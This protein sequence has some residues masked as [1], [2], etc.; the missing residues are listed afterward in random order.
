MEISKRQKKIGKYLCNKA[1]IN[2]RGIDYIAWY[3]KEI[4]VPYGPWKMRGLNGLILECYDKSK[5]Y[6]IISKNI[7]ITKDCSNV[8]KIIENNQLKKVCRLEPV[9]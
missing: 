7:L 8:Q 4:P 3:T 9:C 5:Y 6:R 2:F 1:T